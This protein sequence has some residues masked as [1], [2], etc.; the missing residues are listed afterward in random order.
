MRAVQNT[1]LRAQQELTRIACQLILSRI[2]CLMLY[3]H[4]QRYR[5]RVS[6]A[7]VSKVVYHTGLFLDF[8]NSSQ[9]W[10]VAMIS[11]AQFKGSACTMLNT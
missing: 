5:A 6:V 8:I 11:P 1:V 3:S 4:L 7:L 2:M 9:S 10:F